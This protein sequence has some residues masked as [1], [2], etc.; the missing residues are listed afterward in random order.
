MGAKSRFIRRL[1]RWR[2]SRSPLKVA[3]LLFL[4]LVVIASEARA[5]GDLKNNG[6][7]I[8]NN[9]KIKVKNLAQGLPAVNSG[10]YEFFGASQSIPPM[11]YQNLKFSGSG[12]KAFNGGVPQVNGTFTVMPGVT[13]YADKDTAAMVLGSLAG[14]IDEQGYFAGSIQKTVNLTSI[15]SSSFGGIGLT[16]SYTGSSPGNTTVTRVSGIS[17]PGE[18][19][20]TGNHSIQRY[21]EIS[22]SGS[23]YVGTMDFTYNPGMELNSL[24]ENSLELWRSTNG[25]TNW[26]RQGGTVNTSTHTITKTG[27]LGFSIWTASDLTHPLGPSALEW[28]AQNISSTSGNGQSALPN[29][30]LGSPFVV[31]VTDGYGNPIANTPITF[32]I[33]G[34]PGGASGQNLSVTSVNTNASGQAS[35]ALHLGSASGNYTVTATSGSLTG[36]P[37]SFTATASSILAPPVP[38]AMVLSAG[39]TQIDTVGRQL[40]NSMV[41]TI[42]N[43][44][45]APYAGAPVSFAITSR[46]LGDTLASLTSTSVV[47][48]GAGQALTRLTLG[49]KPGTYTVVAT[50]GS[51]SGASISFN[52]SAL[53]G[54]AYALG[55]PSGNGQSQAVKTALTQPFV[56]SVSDVFGNPI[57]GASVRFAITRTPTGATG[58]TITDTLVLTNALGRAQTLLTLG[59]SVGIY[60]VS[61]ISGS[62]Q[63]SPLVFTT[64]ATAAG[65]P[66]AAKS[67]VLKTGNGQTGTVAS[68]VTNPFVVTV[69]DQYGN[70]F[71]GTTVNFS[72]ASRPSGDT[73]ATLTVVSAVTNASGQVATSLNLGTKAGAYTVVATSSGLSGSPL[74]FSATALAGAAKTLAAVSGNNQTGTPNAILGQPLVVTVSDTYGNLVTGAGVSFAITSAPTGATGQSLSVTNVVTGANGQ[75]S[76]ILT[77]GSQGGQYVVSATSGSLTG[78][79]ALFT[80]TVTT[81]VATRMQYA[82]GDKQSAEVFTRL[83]S[84]LVVTIL[85]GSGNPVAGQPVQFTIAGTPAGAAGASL[86]DALVFTNAQGQASTSLTVGTKIGS[87]VIAASS[88]SLSG[89]PVSFTVTAV[90]GRPIFM[91]L[92]DG[93]NQTGLAA[94]TLSEPLVVAVT[95]SFGNAK[96]GVLVNYSITSAPDSATGQSLTSSSVVT[97]VDGVASVRLTLGSRLGAYRVT[98]T[99]ASLTGSPA[100]FKLAA[101][102][103]V[104]DNQTGLVSNRLQQPFSTVLL[105]AFG[106][107][108]VGAFVTFTIDSIPNGATGA[109]FNGSTTITVRTDSTG[110]ASVFLTLGNLPGTYRVTASSPALPTGSLIFRASGVAQT[111]LATMIYKSGDNQSAQILTQLATPLE[112]TALDAAGNPLAGKK[113]SF[114][115]ISTPSGAVGQLLSPEVVTTDASGRAATTVKLGSKLGT[116]RIAAT[117][118]G[119]EG[120]PVEFNLHAAEGAALALVYVTGDKQI[121]QINT[122][123]DST[124]VVRV[125]D[126]GDNP[127]PGV[128]V[129][130]SLDSI[131]DGAVGQ[132]LTILNSVTDAQGRAAALLTIGDRVGVYRVSAALSGYVPIYFRATAVT[133]SGAVTLVYLSGTAQS[134]QI[135]TQLAN[136]ISVRVL[137]AFGNPVVGQS[138]TFAADSIPLGATGQLVTPSSVTTDA[139]GLATAFVKLGDKVGTYKFTASSAG[140]AGSPVAFRLNATAGAARTMLLVAGDG[141]VKSIGVQLD[142]A[143]VLRIVD[144]GGNPVQGVS[145]QFTLDSSPNGATGQSLVILNQVTDAQGFAS[146]ILTLGAKIGTYAVTASSPALAGTTL[147]FSARASSGAAAA[148][149]QTSGNEQSAPIFTELGSPFVVTIV[150]IGGNPVPG[151]SVQFA[152]DSIPKTAAGQ[153]IRIVNTTTDANGQAAAFLRLGSKLGRYTVTATSSNLIVST[154]RFAATATVMIGDVNANS[155]VDIADL[156]TVIDHILGRITLTGIDSVKADFNRDGRIDVVDIVA[157]QNYLLTISPVNASISTLGADPILSVNEL[158]NAVDSTTDVKGEFIMTDNGLRFNL[159][160]AVPVKGVEL[161]VR[162]KAG[163]GVARPDVIFDRA[164]VDSFY[165]SISGGELRIVAYNLKNAVLAA[166]DGPLFRLPI[167]ISDAS[168]IESAQLMVSR[169]DNAVIYDQ[170]LARTVTVR[171]AVQG[172]IPTSFVLY[173]NYPN[174]FN[175]RTKIEYEVADAVKGVDVKVQVFNALGE[176]VK[177]L[178]SGPHAGGRFTVI[179]DGTDDA[180]RKLA[181]GAYYYRM[182]SGTYMTAKKMIML[183]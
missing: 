159:T 108:V 156:T 129:L 100:V 51:L 173:Q 103:V 110:L 121:K 102:K 146:A 150:D 174:P 81:S 154:V 94:N 142:S 23:G 37:V 109:S 67:I 19:G 59:D 47:T 12:T 130:F 120:S 88:G 54:S 95:D 96:Q 26:R 57:V 84:P 180:G 165:Y 123:L 137:N 152:L 8:I 28:I 62:L 77:L 75:A 43:Q 136:P 171:K 2:L 105:D 124:F 20:F 7:T 73:T 157:M 32:A 148:L 15:S 64:S 80:A 61:A 125:V 11:T 117:S 116:Y 101:M 183:K 87:Y 99:S 127:V 16:L 35:T 72:I 85:D 46:P 162:F 97:D 126:V 21:Y 38:T 92:A 93:D 132:R 4:W 6:G 27:I 176:K 79:P 30:N 78:S 89:S 119:L 49:T 34:T 22:S 5:S 114:A 44:Y 139:T 143:F 56:V 74:S 172:E 141:Q 161:I 107:P 145:V 179:W 86:S 113:V 128:Q 122:T 70:P 131:P 36:S 42:L 10:L 177:T 58:Q 181:S 17:L 135:L 66:P 71:A 178:A 63:G 91:L 18:T 106:K 3:F 1:N 153:S 149:L 151:V 65:L 45:G 98:A 82:A 90:A 134:G 158:L 24:N 140:L 76:A 133:S 39:N 50:S 138:V 48:N 155:L 167:T 168:A 112:V 170:A 53:T 29:T 31:T 60:E 33:A 118:I 55:L 164:R 166:G 52:S 25:G 147:R 9:G 163:V 69:L 160:N 68:Q 40:S 111:G 13:A 115:I 41:V 182:I 14:T 104:G 169:S 83:A 144:Q 175:A